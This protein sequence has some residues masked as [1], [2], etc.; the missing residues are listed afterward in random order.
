MKKQK[1]RRPTSITVGEFFKR[2]GE[3]LRMRLIGADIG[4]DRKISEPTVNRPGLALSGFY[5][6]FAY[7]RIQVVGNSER[8]YLLNLG[9]EERMQRFRELCEQRIPCV[10]VSRAKRLPDGMLECANDNGIS[11]FG[12]PMVSMKFMNAAT[13][14]LE[15]DF[16]PETTEHGSM[17]DVRGIGILIKGDS[18]TGKSESVLG[19]LDRGASLVADDMVR[20]RPVEEGE[21]SGT[22]P[23]ISRSHMEVRGLGIINAA[24]LF[25]VGSIRLEKR[26]DMVIT[27]KSI[28]DINELDRIGM[29]R[30]EYEIL[31]IK[32]PHVELPVAPGRDLA[33][34]IE[35]AALDQKLRSFGHNAALEFEKKLVETMR[36][37]RIK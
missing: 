3:A 24:A 1:I 12:S 35:L 28:S 21:L 2:H 14:N 5:R 32:V 11:V 4:L 13:I 26:L 19:L 30:Q 27:L 29:Q 25:G 15:H 9:E 7:R 37:N 33:G 17:V 36:Q 8:S 23:E 22:A 20:F 16:A 10:V 6:Y 18:G 34:L 31:G